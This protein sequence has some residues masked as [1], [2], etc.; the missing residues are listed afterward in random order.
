MPN[1]APLPTILFDASTGA[2]IGNFTD[3]ENN[4]TRTANIR[5]STKKHK[6]EQLG[7]LF[8]Y[9]GIDRNNADKS[10]ALLVEA[11]KSAVSLQTLLTQAAILLYR[12][13]LIQRK[14]VFAAALAMPKPDAPF[15]F[16]QNEYAAAILPDI[17]ATVS[18][19]QFEYTECV[20]AMEVQLD[21]FRGVT[22][23]ASHYLQ[24]CESVAA[25]LQIV[26]VF[27]AAAKKLVTADIM[28]ELIARINSRILFNDTL[29]SP[30]TVVVLKSWSVLIT[31]FKET[32]TQQAQMYAATHIMMKSVAPTAFSA[33]FKISKQILNKDDVE[34]TSMDAE[35]SNSPLNLLPPSKDSV[36]ESIDISFNLASPGAGRTPQKSVS[37]TRATSSNATFKITSKSN[38]Q[39]IQQT[40]T[41]ISVNN[42]SPCNSNEASINS[43]AGNVGGDVAFDSSSSYVEES[44]GSNDI[45]T[46]TSSKQKRRR[47]FDKNNNQ[48]AILNSSQRAFNPR[49]L[50]KTSTFSGGDN[51]DFVFNKTDIVSQMHSIHNNRKADYHDNVQNST[52]L[53]ASALSPDD[54]F[55]SS[56]SCVTMTP[57]HSLHNS[58]TLPHGSV[59][60][61]QGSNMANLMATRIGSTFEPESL[62]SEYQVLVE[63][64][65]SHSTSNSILNT[66]T[67][68][69]VTEAPKQDCSSIQMHTQDKV[70]DFTKKF[71]QSRITAGDLEQQLQPLLPQLPINKNDVWKTAEVATEANEQQEVLKLDE[72]SAFSMVNLD[73]TSS[74][75]STFKD[76]EGATQFIPGSGGFR[77][78]DATQGQVASEAN[79]TGGTSKA[80]YG[81][82]DKISR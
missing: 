13:R 55:A 30:I 25:E 67:V 62:S 31:E 59:S 73:N 56:I 38:D 43:D 1:R 80:V 50:F 79:S 4:Q 7:A 49:K 65:N 12:R 6:H 69:I 5:S 57:L 17:E 19:L 3:I 53:V 63:E 77:N 61:F 45:R 44:S 40:R 33:N 28:R 74:D 15:L 24:L 26:G 11:K 8:E 82:P 47:S 29:L 23:R 20:A 64:T 70:D 60:E 42:R 48:T 36:A 46:V 21:T 52:D 22:D 66:T 14:R 18:A 54:S 76:F 16:L 35:N 78:D 71:Q 32:R 81:S 75:F 9:I 41:Q 68:S 34:E 39:Q 37:M 10:L 27:D 2:Q 58:N 72:S 51:N